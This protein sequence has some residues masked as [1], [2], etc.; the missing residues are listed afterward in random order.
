MACLTIALP[1]TAPVPFASTRI[2]QNPPGVPLVS[3]LRQDLRFPAAPIPRYQTRSTVPYAHMS[4]FP[5]SRTSYVGIPPIH[6]GHVLGAN[7]SNYWL[8]D[9]GTSAHMTPHLSDIY[10]GSLKLH[11]GGVTVAN[12]G[13]SRVTHKGEVHLTLFEYRYQKAHPRVIILHDVLVVP[14]LAS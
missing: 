13:T 14:D 7:S 10:P 11:R 6:H 9:S 4:R 12:S 8:P 1:K 3:I 2:P 5:T